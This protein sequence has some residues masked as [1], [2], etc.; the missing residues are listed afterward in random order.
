[1]QMNDAIYK[2]WQ[3]LELHGKCSVN[4]WERICIILRDILHTEQQWHSVECIPPLKP[5]MSQNRHC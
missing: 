3:E 2:Q 4:N 5:L 1:M